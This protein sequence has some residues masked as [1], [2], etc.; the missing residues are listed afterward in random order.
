MGLDNPISERLEPDVHRLQVGAAIAL[1]A[2]SAASL[3][4]GIMLMATGDPVP[5]EIHGTA[6]DGVEASLGLT[7]LGLSGR[8]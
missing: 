1:L 4:V 2:V 8:F 3:G 7:P 5:C 6:H